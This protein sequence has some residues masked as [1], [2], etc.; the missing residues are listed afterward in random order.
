[1][2][3]QG[4]LL[5]GNVGVG[6]GTLANAVAAE[7]VKHSTDIVFVGPDEKGTISIERVRGL[8]VATRDIRRSKQVVVVDDIDKMSYDAQNAFL[9]LLEEPTDDVFFILTSH[10]AESLLST[11][12]SRVHAITVR[13]IPSV[14][15][16]SLLRKLHITDA[17]K[18]QQ[19][20][21]LASGLP[22]ELT[23]L[24]KNEGYFL[25]QS[26]AIRVARDFLAG[27][28]Y[29]RLVIANKLT[30]RVDAL[31]FVGLVARLLDFSSKKKVGGLDEKTATAIETAAERISNNGHVRT[32]LINLSFGV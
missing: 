31:Q 15:A 7:L 17:T 25:E 18:L 2:P 8:Y 13:E 9:K 6:L 5:S 29:E 4:L 3:K 22:A 24:A 11:I 30:N 32:Q 27:S 16:Q 21:F 12:A 1:M 19:M 23:R 26:Q 20:L 28:T 14:D 10:T